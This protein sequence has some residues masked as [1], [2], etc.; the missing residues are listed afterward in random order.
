MEAAGQDICQLALPN[1]APGA[2]ALPA[3]PTSRG[4]ARPGTM[5][6]VRGPV[7]SSGHQNNSLMQENRPPQSAP[8]VFSIKPEPQQPKVGHRL[9]PCMLCVQYK[10]GIAIA[11]EK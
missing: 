1:R 2:A 5:A 8:N 9:T 7:G 11:T 3:R 10:K 6:G 4:P